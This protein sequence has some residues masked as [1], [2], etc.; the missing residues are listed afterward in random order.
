MKKLW[1]KSDN[2]IIDTNI[3]SYTIGNDYLLD[4]DLVS[5]DIQGSRAHA[6]GLQKI[7]I[8]TPHELILLENGLD[9]ILE[10]WK[11]GEFVIAREQEDMHTAIEDFLTTTCGEVGKKIHTGR[12]RNDQILVALRLFS[13][14]KLKAVFSLFEGL[15]Q[16][17]DIAAKKYTSFNMPGYT[18]MQRAMPTT[19]EVWL[20]AYHD[21]LIDDVIFLKSVGEILNQ[22]P[23]GSA[24]GYGEN[25][26]GIDREFTAKELGFLNVQKNP[27]Y[28]AMSRG[29]FELMMMQALSQIMMD[30]G[31]FASDL[32]LFTTKEFRFFD[33]PESFKTGSSIMPQKKNFDVLE[34]MRGNVAIFNGYVSQIQE[35]IKNLP[36]GY[37]RDFQLMKE[38]F[39]KGVKLAIDTITIAE[40]VASNLQVNREILEQACTP[41]LYATDEAYRLVKNGMPFRDAYR[42]IGKQYQ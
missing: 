2:H 15:I 12:S 7:G 3:E 41:D 34:L 20:G 23:L 1:Q 18:H 14:D 11:K 35:L 33:L 36:L 32:L 21:A 25:I 22:N 16:A 39:L 31:K 13:L 24:A 38:P 40:K 10:L 28:C 30:L 4:M 29:K 26:L 19:V 42:E 9:V 27:I 37:N 17:F 5:Y 6:R 8:L